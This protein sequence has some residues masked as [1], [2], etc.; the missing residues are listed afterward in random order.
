VYAF[1]KRLMDIVVALFAL[2]V[3]SPLL[4]VVA[5]L[6]RLTS[7]GPALFRQQRAGLRRRPFTLLKF[8]SMR[9]DAEGR[10]HEIAHHNE[11]EGPVF[12]MRD[13]PRITR[14]GRWLRRLSIDELPQLLNVLKGEMSLVGPRPLP[15]GEAERLP[16]G[17][18]HRHDVPPGLTGLWQVRG[19]NDLPFDQMMELDL[20]YVE[21][22]SFGLDLLILA[23]TIPAVLCCRGAR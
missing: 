23:A 4:A 2:V 17:H 15:V 1:C 6:V 19:R 11:M 22:C 5:V 20:E 21:R 8:R 18:Q 9:A 12:K 7:H 3:L 10:R 14:L 16:P 13:D